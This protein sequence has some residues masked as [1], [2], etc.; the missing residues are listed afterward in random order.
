MWELKSMAIVFA[1][2]AF[3]SMKMNGNEIFHWHEFS[4]FI[5]QT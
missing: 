4:I 5:D 2:Y 3:F 1:L